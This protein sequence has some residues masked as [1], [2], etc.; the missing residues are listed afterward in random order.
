MLNLK[1]LTPLACGHLRYV[2]QHPECAQRLIK[3][4]RA[5]VIDARWGG[6]WRWY[7]RLPRALHYTGFVRELKEYIA[8]Q[9]RFADAHPPIAAT[10]GV[11]ETD[12]GLGLVVEKIRSAD[13]TLAPTLGALVKAHGF[14]PS[15]EA[16]FENFIAQLLQYNVIVGDIHPRN[17]VYGNDSRGGPRL[18][19]IDGFGEKNIIPRCSMSRSINQWNTQRHRRR[20]LQTL[21]Q[22]AVTG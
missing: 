13:S 19:L 14:T 4:M 3:I 10:L 21:R 1:N 5:D 18:V 8:I 15:I 17:I 22:F 7:K 20:L 12:L 2:Y 9:A 11:V 6:T 16:E